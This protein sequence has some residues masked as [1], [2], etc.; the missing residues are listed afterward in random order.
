MI[1]NENTNAD[2]RKY[3]IKVN[4]KIII[5]PNTPQEY[6]VTNNFEECDYC[7]KATPR[8]NGNGTGMYCDKFQMVENFRFRR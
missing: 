6:N 1:I 2:K 8:C 5:N 7:Q 4:N 3:F